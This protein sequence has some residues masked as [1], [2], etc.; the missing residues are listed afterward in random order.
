LNFIHTGDWHLGRAF[1]NV[2]LLEDQAYVLDQFIACI[3]ER[4]PD[5]VVIAGD[6]YDRSVPNTDA[7]KLL[8]DTLTRLVLDVQVPVML[9]AGN[10]DSPQRLQFGARL[11]ESRRL[12]I[13]GLLTHPTTFIQMYDDAGPVCFYPLP[14]SEPPVFREYFADEKIIDYESAMRAWIEQVQNMHAQSAR[15]V[16]ITHAFVMGGETSE[17]ERPLSVGGSSAVNAD[18]L[19]NFNYVALGHL[20]RPQTIAG[21]TIYYAGSLLKYSFSEA[22]HEKSINWVEMDST[23]QCKIERISLTPKRDVR[24]VEGYLDDVLKAPAQANQNDLI[25][26]KL[27]DKRAIL[28]TMGKLRQ[29]YPNAMDI[30]PSVSLEQT[31]TELVHP[32][33]RRTDTVSLFNDFF[34]QV[35]GD[36]LG[37]E[38]RQAFIRIV[39]QLRQQ[40]REAE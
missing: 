39:D 38:E 9:I 36:P 27:L 37:D 7:V 23:G 24:I 12:Y 32:D 40:E 16:L 5:L 13:Y 3:R 10:H 33:L 21:T 4:K 6:V 19:R 31:R 22:D 8:D 15:S 28:D 18:I 14:Y 17:S 1:Y 30:D 20:H 25:Q 34:Q 2:S 29:V 26:F 11:M 35:T